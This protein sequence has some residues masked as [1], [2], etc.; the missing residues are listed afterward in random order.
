MT[1]Y[2]RLAGRVGRQ[3]ARELLRA[4]VNAATEGELDARHQPCDGPD[5]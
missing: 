5:A 1:A 2:D 3:D 4:A